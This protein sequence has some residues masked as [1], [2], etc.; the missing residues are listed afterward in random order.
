MLEKKKLT[1]ELKQ[2]VRKLLQMYL[3]KRRILEIV[4]T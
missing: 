3:L 4:A 2:E 1:S